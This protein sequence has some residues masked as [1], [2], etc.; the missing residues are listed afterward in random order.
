MK[1]KRQ[2]FR[3]PSINL[4]GEVAMCSD[5]FEIHCFSS[6]ESHSF[7]GHV[8]HAR[9]PIIACLGVEDIARDARR[10]MAV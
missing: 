5:D 10:S 8:A 2:S 3:R 4:D 1:G 9:R 7:A 6:H